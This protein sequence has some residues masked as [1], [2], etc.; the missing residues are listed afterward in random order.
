MPNRKT[1]FLAVGWIAA[2]A[3]AIFVL[4][5]VSRQI[6]PELAPAPVEEGIGVVE[7]APPAEAKIAATVLKGR[8]APEFSLEDV[9]GKKYSLADWK[10]KPLAIL[11]W[12]SWNN[13]SLRALEMLTNLSKRLTQASY[14]T[15]SSQEPYVLISNYLR[16]SQVE[17]PVLLDTEGKTTEAYKTQ[18]LPAFVF[19][20]ESGKITNIVAQPLPEAGLEIEIGKLVGG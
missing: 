16:R 11:F 2:I 15:I 19:I 17:L 13:E 14:V 5:V 12:A 9:A 4:S 20:N 8:T 18:F 10:G 1:I 3:V 6:L 7:E